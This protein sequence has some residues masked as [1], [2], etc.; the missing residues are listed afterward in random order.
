[1]CRGELSA[2]IARAISNNLCLIS[3]AFCEL[4]MFVKENLD[5]KNNNFDIRKKFLVIN[6]LFSFELC[7]VLAL[8]DKY[9]EKGG[10]N[11]H[12]VET[13]FFCDFKLRS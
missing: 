5:R 4:L 11:L 6:V 8:F 12:F 2:V 10:K 7:Q 9:F 13:L 1:M 3:Y